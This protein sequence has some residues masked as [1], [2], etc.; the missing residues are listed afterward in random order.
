[1]RG[2][3]ALSHWLLSPT[4]TK[5]KFSPS[6]PGCPVPQRDSSPPFTSP[7]VRKTQGRTWTQ[8]Q[9]DSD[10][11]GRHQHISKHTGGVEGC[12]AG[13]P[14]FSGKR[15]WNL[16]V[17]SHHGRQTWP[18]WQGFALCHQPCEPGIGPWVSDETLWLQPRETPSRAPSQAVPRLLPSRNC[19]ITNGY[20]LQP[21][22]LCSFVIWQQKWR[23]TP[24]RN[25]THP[26]KLK[27][28]HWS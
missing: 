4:E 25:V 15:W 28:S 9:G 3:W 14:G 6:D 2:S 11:R 26:S 18:T 5:G 1:M 16:H 24:H 20:G 22:N 8:L 7:A 23:Q 17:Q 10:L 19:G 13:S 12:D 27:T 21:L